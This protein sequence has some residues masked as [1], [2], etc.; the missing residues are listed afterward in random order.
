M[1]SF[2]QK[3]AAGTAGLA[4]T[5][6]IT[7]KSAKIHF[8]PS[9]IPTAQAGSHSREAGTQRFTSAALC[10]SPGREGASPSLWWSRGMWTR[11]EAA[12]ELGDILY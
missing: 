12:L 4:R 5:A 1:K 6:G 2:S 11:G 8:P 9:A 10:L 7:L 3:N